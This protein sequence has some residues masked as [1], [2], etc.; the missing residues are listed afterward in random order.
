MN[1]MR[2]APTTTTEAPMRTPVSTGHTTSSAH[3]RLQTPKPPTAAP[4]AVSASTDDVLALID[5]AGP[6]TLKDIA[7]GL[8]VSLRYASSLVRR[9]A[10]GGCLGLDE[11]DRHRVRGG[12]GSS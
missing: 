9:L 3:A 2:Y 8:N 5:A 11:W 6:L 4:A 12:C 7:G 1:A 10:A